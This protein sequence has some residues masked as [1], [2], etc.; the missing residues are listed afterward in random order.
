M[1][2]G[3]AIDTVTVSVFFDYLLKGRVDWMAWRASLGLSLGL[4]CGVCQAADIWP[5]PHQI[6]RF[7]GAETNQTFS[8]AV[9]DGT[10]WKRGSGT[11]TFAAPA[12]SGIS[13]LN[14]EA[15]RA[16]IDL[17]ATSS[18]IP[19]L[20]DALK[21]KIKVWLDATRNVVTDESGAYVE[22]W[23][24]RRETVADGVVET[25]VRP[26]AEAGN[27]RN[28]FNDSVYARE[29]R[30]GYLA[31]VADLGGKAALDFGTNG[32]NG[33]NARWLHLVN[34]ETEWSFVYAREVFAVCARNSGGGNGHL[35][36]ISAGR[37][38]NPTPA[39]VPADEYVW[40]DTQNVRID[41]GTTWL[42][43]ELR[44]SSRLAVPDTAWHLLEGR[45]PLSNDN[46]WINQ[47]GLDR[48]LF[49]SSGNGGFRLA[50]LIV[51]QKRLSEFERLRV[52]G[53]LQKKW[54]SGRTGSVGTI[55][56]NTNSV[57]EVRGAASTTGALAGGGD[58]VKTGE[59]R[60]TVVNRGFTGS[61]ELRAGSVRSDTLVLD[62]K[63]SGQTL[64]T[65]Q[66]GITTRSPAAAGTVSKAG[67]G[68]LAV[69]SLP[70]D[71]TK[72]EVA[73]GVLRLSPHPDREPTGA[74]ADLPDGDFESYA[75]TMSTSL[76]ENVG[77]GSG[78]KTPQSRGAWSFDR[79]G[80]ASGGNLVCI[81]SSRTAQNT[82]GS[83]NLAP[84]DAWGLGYNGMAMLY[85][86]HGSA[87]GTFTV[88]DA[89][90]YR[91]SF[92]C[93]TRSR[94]NDKVM[95]LRLDGT[96]FRQMTTFSHREFMRYEVTLPWL[97][98]GEHT[99][100]F[101]DADE[102]SK[103]FLCDD[104]KIL[105]FA[106][107]KNEPVAVAIANASFEEPMS[108]YSYSWEYDTYKGLLPTLADCTGWTLPSESSEKFFQPQIVRRWDDRQ[109][110][111]NTEFAKLGI[112][113]H[114]EEI[115]DG[116][117][118]AQIYATKAF[119]QTVEFPSAGRYR[120]SYALAKRSGSA[121]QTVV[122]KVGERTVGLS[123]VSHD[124]FRRKTVEFDVTEAGP[125]LLSFS[126]LMDT[127]YNVSFNGISLMN[128][129]AYLDDVSLVR[130]GDIT[131]DNLLKDGDFETQ[132]EGGWTF[133]GGAG[134][135][136]RTAA[137]SN[138]LFGDGIWQYNL[139]GHLGTANK[140][141]N[142]RPLGPA[143][144]GN[145]AALCYLQDDGGMEGALRQVVTLTPGRYELSY[146]R[147]ATVLDANA[148]TKAM[149]FWVA[150]APNQS[151]FVYNRLHESSVLDSEEA[152]NEKVVFTI[153]RTGA[154]L[155][156]FHSH[157]AQPAVLTLDDVVLRKVDAPA[158]LVGYADA[159]PE[160]LDVTV[161]NGCRLNLDFDGAA[162]VHSL[163]F[164][165]RSLVGEISHALYPAWVMG[166]GTLYVRSK[167][168]M[169]IMR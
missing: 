143:N 9:S 78:T 8:G 105:P 46:C 127:T 113:A 16:V 103:T 58:V 79:S 32:A 89:G 108:N 115:P 133:H 14:V 59:G 10:V 45:L 11:T 140:W 21:D 114:P 41:K 52:Q 99:V 155:I 50:E 36:C 136:I 122:A 55:A 162:I 62:V 101:S 83:W 120:L 28:A 86:C 37:T 48:A 102:E 159:I 85:I 118:C 107:Q 100:T 147:A 20:P 53:Y 4:A 81:L 15:G 106:P 26:Y 67:T 142:S 63:E 110:T 144:G 34:G 54:F 30:P 111:D 7:V 6:V 69:S 167:G 125:Q 72:L 109:A 22:K 116:F 3:M 135:V 57:A 124:E 119:S 73:A 130:V 112:A 126:G 98:A 70:S 92:Q 141:P 165:G 128:G 169:I 145:A 33:E 51:F 95:S 157:F 35:L 31:T 71:A 91:L 87:T 168:T 84:Y 23:Y 68:Y 2:G 88:R 80:Y 82:E 42:D 49:K 153:T 38:D 117:L 25:P 121:V 150:V 24:D 129:G 74:T 27:R 104:V 132:S 12:F 56:V 94:V 166:R 138:G 90:Y 77:G 75:A 131:S 76:A 1:S 39:W 164:N 152:Q 65:G 93:S 18:V 19:E 154:Y 96:E 97:S 158:P 40:G 163:V 160:T 13:T 148:I 29:R 60:L 146:R 64:S 123:I 17:D 151:P 44:P 134:H 137:E 66:T 61:F 149:Y 139:S 47:I 161:A 5:T 156:E 43:G